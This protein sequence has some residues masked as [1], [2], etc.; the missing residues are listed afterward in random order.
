MSE[1]TG[2]VVKSEQNSLLIEIKRD[3]CSSCAHHSHCRII[4][5]NESYFVTVER[6]FSNNAQVGDTVVLETGASRIIGLSLLLYIFPVFSVLAF[7]I[8]GI[9]MTGDETKGMI[10]GMAGGLLAFLI[11]YIIDRKIGRKLK[12]KIT[13]VIK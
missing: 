2:T 8:I 5:K 7:T 12:H 4:E 6:E 1:V 10:A 9:N 11:I 13:R 3:A